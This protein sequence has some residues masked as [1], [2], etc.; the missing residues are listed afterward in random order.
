MFS[1]LNNSTPYRYAWLSCHTKMGVNLSRRKLCCVPLICPKHVRPSNKYAISILPKCCLEGCTLTRQSILCLN[2]RQS[3]LCL[4]FYFACN[5][6]IHSWPEPFSIVFWTPASRLWRSAS[7]WINELEMT[8]YERLI[9]LCTWKVQLMCARE[10][11]SIKMVE[12]F[13]RT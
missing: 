4:E 1:C 3:I 13:F 6:Y 11:C 12:A 7:V 9:V 2:P 10:R 5:T 8:E